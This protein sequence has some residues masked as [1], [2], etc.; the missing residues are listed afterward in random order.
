MKPRFT[1]VTCTRNS[2]T[3]LSETV[4]SVR[5]QVHTDLEHLFVDGNSTDGTLEY[6]RTLGG[7]VRIIEGV[8]GGISRAMN[9]GI[10]AATGQVVA[11]LHSDDYYPN[12]QVLSNV[13]TAMND[14]GARWLF[15]RCL[16]DIDGK[17]IPE[18]HAIPRYSLARVLKGNFIPHPATFV[19]KSL[20]DECGGFDETL[21]YA[22]DYDLWLRLGQVAVPWQLNEHL[23]VFRDHPGSLSSSNR[24]AAFKE[25]W[26]VR[27]RYM[28][29]AP[30]S[31]AY[32]W[33]HYLVR[34]RR[35]SARGHER[36][37]A[38]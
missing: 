11:H 38:L 3:T 34:L 2:L 21:K 28:S 9:I 19:E 22:M 35:V 13:S 26:R 18:G 24:L 31:Q 4:Q 17:R 8:T 23:A 5:E 16:T 29:K 33:A 6:L 10:R 36:V 1:I 12:S 25:D 30:W 14:S 15:G 32:H 7:K 20:F 37:V 27:Q